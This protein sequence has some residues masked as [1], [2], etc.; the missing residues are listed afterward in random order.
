MI[1]DSLI[2]NC[3]SRYTFLLS[4]W[5]C[6]TCCM[7]L[8]VYSYA[9]ETLCTQCIECPV[10]CSATVSDNWPRPP[11]LLFHHAFYTFISRPICHS[12]LWEVPSSPPPPDQNMDRIPLHSLSPYI[13]TPPA[14]A[15]NISFSNVSAIRN[16]IPPPTI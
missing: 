15:F 14:F 3:R 2:E 9:S 6:S 13:L 1:R 5:M 12:V 10:Y 7:W 16:V 8:C 4:L 11:A